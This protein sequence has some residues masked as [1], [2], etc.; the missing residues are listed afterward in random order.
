MVPGCDLS[1]A[2]P[3]VIGAA[4][5]AR[6][7]P[8]DALI[9]ALRDLF[10][11]GCEAPPR[12]RHT[13]SEAGGAPATLLLM[14]AWIPERYLGVK[15]V[16][17]H[18]ANAASGEPAL[19]AAY[20]LS[21]AATGRL[22]AFIDGD[23]ITLRRTAAASALAA[24]Y[25]ARQDA[26]SLLVV[27][28]GQVAAELPHAYRAVRAIRSVAVWARR[29]ER[30]AALAADLAAAGFDACAAPDLERAAASA[31]IVS[32]ATL[33]MAPLVRGRWLKGG[34][35]LD[36]VGGFTP[37][38]RETDDAAVA[39][40]SVYVDTPAALQ[41][42]G[43]LVQPAASGV[44]APSRVRGTLADLCRG[45][46]RGRASEDELTLFKSVGTALEDLAAAILVHESVSAGG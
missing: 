15:T 8:Y 43:D 17:V 34:A 4:E 1:E 18:P 31:D 28:A 46:A 44:F 29:P 35:H 32:C 36:L 23:A 19:H 25:L 30:A 16:T 24:S 13:L 5:A 6:A 33:S 7:L 42:A 26:A 9:P 3:R 37:A 40:A 10:A 21:S 14:P 38:M 11:A 12:H 41:E 27:G 45:T 39:R 20:L 2:G 22:L